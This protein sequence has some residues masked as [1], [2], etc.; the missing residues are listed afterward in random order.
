MKY[1]T[2]PCEAGLGF[3]LSMDFRLV[4]LLFMMDLR[5]RSSPGEPEINAIIFLIKLIRWD[6]IYDS[7]FIFK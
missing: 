1:F 6:T 4:L 7:K 3:I 5:Q 2:Y